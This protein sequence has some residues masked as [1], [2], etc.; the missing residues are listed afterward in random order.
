MI[1]IQRAYLFGALWLLG[2]ARDLCISFN[3]FVLFLDNISYVIAH[4]S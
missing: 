1:C 3:A 2:A 4:A